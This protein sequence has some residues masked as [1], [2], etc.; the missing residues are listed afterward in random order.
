MQFIEG[1]PSNYVELHIFAL[2]TYNPVISQASNLDV[3]DE[4]GWVLDI[5]E[6]WGLEQTGKLIFCLKEVATAQVY[7]VAGPAE[8]ISQFLSVSSNSKQFRKSHVVCLP[9]YL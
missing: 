1:F 5:R 4:A 7:P 2:G 6:W 8:Q 9:A 3:Y